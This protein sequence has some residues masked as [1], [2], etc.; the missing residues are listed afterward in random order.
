MNPALKTLIKL[1]FKTKLHRTAGKEGK[2]NVGA[3]LV[4]IFFSF[5]V[6]AIYILAVFFLTQM[7]IWGS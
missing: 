2:S 3:T 1:E 7:L 6:Y 4:T 5:A